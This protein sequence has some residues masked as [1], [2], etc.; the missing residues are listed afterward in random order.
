[1]WRKVFRDMP[2]L[3]DGNLVLHGRID[4]IV[5]VI[6]MRKNPLLFTAAHVAPHLEGASSR[7]S[8][9][10][11][12]TRHSAAEPGDKFAVIVS[13]LRV[14]TNARIHHGAKK[15]ING[16][17]QPDFQVGRFG[18]GKAPVV[19]ALNYIKVIELQRRNGGNENLELV[20]SIN[21]AGILCET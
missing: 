9:E 1:M 8:T 7:V 21:L 20:Q 12:V 6:L 17:K 5:G 19:C 16:Q 15:M 4:D 10:E 3:K 11:V 14:P 13:E 18:L 2:G